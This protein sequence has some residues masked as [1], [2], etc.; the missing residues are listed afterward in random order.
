MAAHEAARTAGFT[1]HADQPL[2][3]V[4]DEVDGRQVVRYFTSEEDADAATNGQT[5]Q[6]ALDAI[7]AWSDLDLN[8]MLDELDRIRHGSTPTPPIDEL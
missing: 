5:L 8:E 2:I 4:P 3:A 7:G 1:A 6:K